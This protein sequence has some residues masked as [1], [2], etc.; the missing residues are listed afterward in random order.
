MRSRHNV[1]QNACPRCRINRKFCY[2][3]SLKRFDNRTPVTIIMHRK[4]QLLTSNTATLAKAVLKNAT[5]L[6][7]GVPGQSIAE[8]IPIHEDRLPL[9][10]FP[11]PGAAE[12]NDEFLRQI[13]GRK[14]HLIV[15][16]G[17]WSQAKKIK[18]RE[19]GLANIQSACI[20][21]VRK[22]AYRLRRQLHDSGLCTFEAISRALGVIESRKLE[23]NMNGML[24]LKM[25]QMA[26]GR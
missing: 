17:T 2:C 21:F 11:D 4:E 1:K 12:L 23:E 24:R 9:Y 6:V 25:Q 15:P 3:A 13:G 20:P 16:D 18:R 19:P 22:S 5:L 26:A 8:K 14:I 10:L 7:R